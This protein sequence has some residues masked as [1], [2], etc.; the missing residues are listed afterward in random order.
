M[1]R[2]KRYAL[3]WVPGIWQ[4]SAK[5]ELTR[6]ESGRVFLQRAILQ[7]AVLQGAVLLGAILLVPGRIDAAES[8]QSTTSDT[9]RAEAIHAIPL[10][11]LSPRHRR[12]VRKVIEHATLYRRLPTCVVDCN[13]GLFTYVARN[14]EV[15]VAIWRELGV[16]HV[17]LQR[18]GPYTFDFKDSSGT[19]G[20]LTLVEQQCDAN[21]Q[22]RLVLWAEGSYEAKPLTHP[23]K[24]QCVLLLRSGSLKETNGRRFVAAQLDTFV[25]VDRASLQLFAKAIHPWVGATVDRNF[26]D[27]LTFISHLSH[28]AELRPEAID[29][30]AGK[31][32]G[33]YSDRREQLVRVAYQ[34]A[35]DSQQWQADHQAQSKTSDTRLA[36]FTEGGVGK[37][38][39]G[40]AER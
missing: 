3:S 22:N 12:Q 21:A 38:K 26:S 7:R 30:L 36:R 34:C 14:P 35:D 29:K 15:M 11:K 24:A 17:Q 20:K 28:T 6:A 8:H 25:H 32:T 31:L 39:E 4:Q 16:T 19:T 2:G 27:T 9:A 33:I 18:T 23:V 10:A 5:N 40:R 13:P 37:G 1:L